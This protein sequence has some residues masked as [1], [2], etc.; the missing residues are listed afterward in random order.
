MQIHKRS[1]VDVAYN[2]S[3]TYHNWQLKAT[4]VISLSGT[5]L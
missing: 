5:L 3:S 4:Q 2:V 1:G